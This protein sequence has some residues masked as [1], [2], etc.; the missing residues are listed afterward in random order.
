M[1][2]T[3]GSH[4]R[5]NLVGYVALFVALGGTTYAATG[6]NFI[7]GQA[8]SAGATTSLSAP[9]AGKKALQLTNTS[10]GAGATALGLNVASGHTPFTVN[11]GTKVTNLNADKL[12]SLD[13]TA[14]VPS[15][16]LGALFFQGNSG[17]TQTLATVGPFTLKGKCELNGNGL[18][19]LLIANTPNG[20][21]A[22]G[23]FNWWR[24]DDYTTDFH[25][26]IGIVLNANTDYRIA[27]DFSGAQPG[28]FVRID[29]T[30]MLVQP[31]SSPIVVRVDFDGA[32]DARSSPASCFL[33]GTATKGA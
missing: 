14:F 10:T 31:G 6:G 12:D 17:T 27:G 1:L 21:L 13:S 32:A 11:S 7:L 2:K 16:N 20:G 3:V 4:L 19:V 22:N 30:I 15:S 25:I 8:N 9:I 26:P 23:S 24:N 33:H 29:G 18:V 28:D 5:G